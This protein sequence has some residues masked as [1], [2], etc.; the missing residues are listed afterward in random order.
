MVGLVVVGVHGDEMGKLAVVP[1]IDG[2]NTHMR[3]YVCDYYVP[4]QVMATAEV[5]MPY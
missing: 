3:A 1:A 5:S 4:M 2:N